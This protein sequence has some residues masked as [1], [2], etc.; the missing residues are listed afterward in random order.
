MFDSATAMMLVLSVTNHKLVT[1]SRYSRTAIPE[2]DS[3]DDWR[4]FL[5]GLLEKLQQP[6]YFSYACGEWF[7]W[8]VAVVANVSSSHD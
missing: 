7:F 3:E 5:F 8:I 1:R 2:S 6:T 4:T